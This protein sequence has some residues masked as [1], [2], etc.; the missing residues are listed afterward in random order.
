MST[1]PAK[2]V[3]SVKT[4]VATKTKAQAVAKEIGIPLSTLINAYLRKVA[5]DGTVHF[6]A[7][8]QMTPQMERVIEKVEA[9][10]TRGET[11]GPFDTAEEMIESLHEQTKRL[12][13]AR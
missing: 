9:E 8:E 10:I 5:G 2:T 7:T 12:K 13:N 4:D 1:K 6:T 3:I 11:Y